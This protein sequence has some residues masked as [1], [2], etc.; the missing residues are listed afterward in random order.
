[1]SNTSDTG[2]W[3][4]IG[5]TAVAILMWLGQWKAGEIQAVVGIVSGLVVT[6]F[7]GTQWIVLWRE[8]IARKADPPGGAPK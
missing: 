6:G 2:I 8:K 5:K 7:V 1:M 4:A 3:T